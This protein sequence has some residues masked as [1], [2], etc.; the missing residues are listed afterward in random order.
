MLEKIGKCFKIINGHGT[1]NLLNFY[2]YRTKPFGKIF[3]IPVGQIVTIVDISSHY[4][5]IFLFNNRFYIGCS[6]I[7]KNFN[8]YLEEVVVDKTA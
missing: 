7:S 5:P 8:E 3:V 2:T 4:E 1:S 6:G